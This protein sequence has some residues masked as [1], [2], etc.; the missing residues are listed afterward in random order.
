MEILVCAERTRAYNN[1]ITRST[2]IKRNKLPVLGTLNQTSGFW[3]LTRVIFVEISELFQLNGRVYAGN[4]ARDSTDGSCDANP[5]GVLPLL[6]RV[7]D[8]H[9]RPKGLE[10]VRRNNIA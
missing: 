2:R 9:S 1:T 10:A 6:H 7:I 5:T 4:A 8:E 3:Q